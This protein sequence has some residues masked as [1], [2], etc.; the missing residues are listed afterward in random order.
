MAKLVSRTTNHPS[1]IAEQVRDY[2][3]FFLNLVPA[4]RSNLTVAC[5]GWE[6]CS[7]DYE[8]HRADFAFYGIEYVAQGKGTIVLNGKESPL[9]PG[10]VFAYHPFVAHGIRTDPGDPLVKYFLDFSGKDAR[11]LVGPNV[12]GQ[13]GLACLHNS[14]P[15]HDL[16][17]QILDSG[18]KG[19]SLAK[20]ICAA[21]L[22]LLSL[23]IEEHAHE[24]VKAQSRARQR[25]E[26]CRTHLQTH[27][28]TIRSISELAG[29]MH[30]DPAYLSRLFD[31]FG[32][33]SPREM[34]TRLKVNEAAAHLI[35]GRFT[36]K[37]IA[38]QVGYSD[39]YHFSRVFKKHQGTAP[40]RFQVA[41]WMETGTRANQRPEP[42]RDSID[43]FRSRARMH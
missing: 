37:E 22:E 41:R 5:G 2:R 13:D 8:I 43:R 31:R 9:V 23:R 16:Y 20:R 12:F 36:V 17:D 32:G 42:K 6:R 26:R 29:Q 24:P 18:L 14:Q 10:S 15:I 28:R 11:R 25:F 3:Y 39:P 30:L 34:L 19:G 1:F 21:L 35:G 27:F 40:T 33:E 4:P 7:A 38:A